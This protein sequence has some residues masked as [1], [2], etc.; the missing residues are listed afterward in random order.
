MPHPQ[1]QS[2]PG[3]DL[4]ALAEMIARVA[5]SGQTRFGGEPYI[6][7]PARI[8]DSVWDASPGDYITVAIAWLHDTIEDTTV[9]RTALRD[10]GLSREIVD[11][12]ALLTRSPDE[13]YEHY[14]DRLIK[15][16]SESVLTVK[17]A[18]LHDNLR[19]LEAK[20]SDTKRAHLRERYIAAL[21]RISGEL[22]RR[23]A[24]DQVVRWQLDD[25]LGEA[26]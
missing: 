6:N 18:D 12:V 15:F 8:A 20:F 11:G 9:T 13:S 26:A 7:H 23:E 14:I 4:A 19:D 17:V 5:H 21:V 24:Q 3:Y 25:V 2:P 22:N 16:G 1:Y 10:V